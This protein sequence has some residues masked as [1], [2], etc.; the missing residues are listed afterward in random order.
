VRSA[1]LA[2]AV[3]LT[4][5]VFPSGGPCYEISQTGSWTEPGIWDM[6]APRAQAE[7]WISEPWSP[8][9]SLDTAATSRWWNGTGH[10]TTVRKDTDVASFA[11]FFGRGDGWSLWAYEVPDSWSDDEL[12]AA[13][14][15][16]L[17]QAGA[18]NNDQRSAWVASLFLNECTREQRFEGGVPCSAKVCSTHRERCGYS[19]FWVGPLDL[20]LPLEAW[21]LQPELDDAGHRILRGTANGTGWS[22]R[23]ALPTWRHPM[24]ESEPDVLIDSGN[25]VT[26]GYAA[27]S[28][29]HNSTL[30]NEPLRV[31]DEWWRA[32]ATTDFASLGLPPPTFQD[33]KPEPHGTCG[34]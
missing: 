13:A 33:A 31:V 32:N 27:G 5:C 28:P 25:R 2:F 15:Q 17:R 20:D 6:L 30:A 3:L 24:P 14:E 23:V 1:W 29:A 11:A 22:I 16:F 26:A 19:S 21:N 7:G 8:R 4:G 9:P 34:D 12:E 10:L 18:S